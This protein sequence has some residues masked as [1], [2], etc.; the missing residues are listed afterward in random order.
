MAHQEHANQGWHL[1]I[2]VGHTNPALVGANLGW[3]I[4]EHANQGWHLPV[5]GETRDIAVRGPVD[6]GA[7]RAALQVKTL[8]DR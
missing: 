5:P 4:Q 7:L 6:L 1:P 8:N 2:T 3:H